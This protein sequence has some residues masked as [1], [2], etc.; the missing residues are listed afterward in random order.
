[1]TARRNLSIGLALVIVVGAIYGAVHAL[2][3]SWH[4][5]RA[6]IGRANWLLLLAGWIVAIVVVVLLAQ[7]W[8]AT[9]RTL[10]ADVQF[11]VSSRWFM[12]GQLGKYA[13][14]GVWHIVGQGELA[15]RGG[16]A[17]PLAYS[18]VIL[19]TITLVAGAAVLCI[20]LVALRPRSNACHQQPPG[21]KQP[22]QG[23]QLHANPTMMD[24]VQ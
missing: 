4:E 10:G 12:T 23:P 16:V 3:G 22:P 7:R 1:M 17:R 19:S 11:P 9:M 8:H 15:A 13:P 5:V 21:R 6:A 20:N 2:A 24:V 18:S 14:G